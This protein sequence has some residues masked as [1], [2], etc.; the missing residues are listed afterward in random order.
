LVVVARG[1]TATGHVLK[2]ASLAVLAQLAPS[3][4]EDTMP[5]RGLS[6]SGSEIELTF[7]PAVAG[8]RLSVG[9]R[10]VDPSP[11]S[12]D[13]PSETR[14]AFPLR[15]LARAILSH[16]PLRLGTWS[17]DPSVWVGG[18]A[19]EVEAAEPPEEPFASPPEDGTES[20]NRSP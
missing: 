13:A 15:E 3:D 7:A 16:R 14:F 19:L 6:R 4:A 9:D 1:T 18:I 12:S 20:A 8:G 10:L 2:V 5:L 11:T 17:F